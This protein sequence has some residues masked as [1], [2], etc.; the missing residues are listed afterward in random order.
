MDAEAAQRARTIGQ[1]LRRIRDARDKSLV[2]I[3]GLSG[4]SKS[5][6]DRIELG[7]IAL[8]KLSD[9][10]ALANA[11]EVAP[12]DLVRLPVPAPT[13]GHTDSTTEAVGQVLD[14]IED[15]AP[16]GV[17]LPVAVL[18]EQATRM[19]AQRRACRFAE[20]AT[21]LPGLIRTCTPR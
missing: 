2:V 4:I 16:A 5:K 7:E 12:G 21:D 13:N 9:I 3:A 11:L 14:E 1:R 15:E 19:H 8:D 20:L 6:L 17:V 18:R 10:V